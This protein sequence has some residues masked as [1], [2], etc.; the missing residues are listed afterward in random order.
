N[1]LRIVVIRPTRRALPRLKLERAHL[2][3]VAAKMRGLL[4]AI[5]PQLPLY[6]LAAIRLASGESHAEPQAA[7]VL[8][9]VLITTSV[10]AFVRRCRR[11]LRGAVVPASDR[12]TKADGRYCGAQRSW[13]QRATTDT[14]AV[15]TLAAQSNAKHA[16]IGESR[17]GPKPSAPK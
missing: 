14:T 15:S 7:Q 16:P 11:H 8:C 3:V 1:A 5:V 2:A 10:L 12:N 6:L 9:T 17:P 13:G 4:P